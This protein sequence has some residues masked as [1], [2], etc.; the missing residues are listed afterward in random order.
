MI[1]PAEVDNA[2]GVLPTGQY[3][4]RRSKFPG[5]LAAVNRATEGAPA[6]TQPDCGCCECGYGCRAAAADC[7]DGCL[8]CFDPGDASTGIIGRV[9]WVYMRR[10][11]PQLGPIFSNPADVP[12]LNG[13]D[14]GFG[15]QGPAST[16]A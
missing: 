14:F 12:L 1:D 15:P 9:N 8:E 11:R 7:I 4:E 5:V 10:S 3:T 2:A 6:P 16:P 13:S